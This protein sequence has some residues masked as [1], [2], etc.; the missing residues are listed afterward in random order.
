MEFNRKELIEDCLN[1]FM[2]VGG[3]MEL[4]DRGWREDVWMHDNYKETIEEME[5]KYLPDLFEN[6]IPNK[7]DD[8]LDLEDKIAD[9][10]KESL[11]N[12]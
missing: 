7:V 3:A 8:Y 1:F 10:F 12:L 5:E 6:F 9:F 2:T 11:M 4:A